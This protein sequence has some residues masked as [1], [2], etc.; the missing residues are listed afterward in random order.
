MFIRYPSSFLN[1]LLIGFAFAII[2]LLWAFTDANFAF[3]RLAAQSEKTISNAVETTRISRT[4]QEQSSLMERSARQYYVLYDKLLLANYEQASE[5]FGSAL[6]RLSVLTSDVEQ[7]ERIVAVEKQAL[8]L[9]QAILNNKRAK[10]DNPIFLEVFNQLNKKIKSISRQN[11]FL[12]DDASRQLTKVARKKQKN[13]LMQSLVL[14]PFTLLIAGIIAFLLARPIRRMDTAIRNLGEGLYDQPIGIDGPGDL[15]A[16]GK[17]LDWLRIEL[18]DINE[19]KTQFLRHVSHELKT[20]LTVIR[21][22]T[23]LLHDGVG[24]ILSTQQFEIA[25][26]L[27]D[28][29]I[30]LQNMIE[31]LLNFTRFESLQKQSNLQTFFLAELVKK[32]VVENALSIEHKQLIVSTNIKVN[33]K[34]TSDQEKLMVIFDNL[35]SNA[36]KFTPESG[37]IQISA[38]EEKSWIRIE[39]QDSGPGF[40][41]E[42]QDKVFDTFFRGRAINQGLIKGS[43]LGLTIVKDLIENLGGSIKLNPN[44]AGAHFSLRIPNKKELA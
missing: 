37:H 40:S 5:T 38:V 26:L 44:K 7:L 1:L 35:I 25:Q 10:I 33:D 42:N 36:V 34:I 4:L 2:P 28:N 15:H 6:S 8:I 9:H 29:S 12:I 39:V 11:N 20:P 23:E 19:Q 21:E 16:L 3:G 24:G 43:G 14:I 30:R 18:K 17:R 13:L 22:A 41:E 31:N 27:K 32:V